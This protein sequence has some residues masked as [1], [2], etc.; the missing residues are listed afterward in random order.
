MNTLYVRLTGMCLFLLGLLRYVVAFN[1]EEGRVGE[2][3]GRVG[4][5]VKSI[6]RWLKENVMKFSLAKTSTTT[7]R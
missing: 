7:T 2:G 4:G 1:T 5:R 6:I 3:G